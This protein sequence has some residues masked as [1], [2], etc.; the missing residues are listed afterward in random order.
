[1]LEAS[2]TIHGLIKSESADLL[3][4]Y[5]GCGFSSAKTCPAPGNFKSLNNL[6]NLDKTVT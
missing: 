2:Q 6:H 4:L 1:M 5:K 3:C